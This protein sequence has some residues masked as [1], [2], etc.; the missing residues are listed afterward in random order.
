MIPLNL[1]AFI[2]ILAFD[3]TL[4]VFYPRWRGWRL[5]GR[6]SAAEID[7]FGGTQGVG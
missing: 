3:T 5:R 1:A 6:F 7:F 2:V 4:V